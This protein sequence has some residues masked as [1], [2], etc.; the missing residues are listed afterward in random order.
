MSNDN[1]LYENW[2][3]FIDLNAISKDAEKKSSQKL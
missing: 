1:Q 3:K 2:N